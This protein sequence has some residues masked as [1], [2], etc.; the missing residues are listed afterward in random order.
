MAVGALS[1]NQAIKAVA[2]AKSYLVKDQI[3]ISFQ[4][5][6]K[7]DE[8]IAY[9]LVLT[10]TKAPLRTGMATTVASE[11]KVK[12]DSE[13]YKTAGAIA[14]KIREGSRV[15]VVCITFGAETVYVAIDSISIA[16]QYLKRD[17][18]DLTVS[19]EFVHVETAEGERSGLR[20]ELKSFQI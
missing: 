16:R 5:E 10:L 9:N 14:A 2:I 13:S 18:L 12:R 19:P 15:A 4:S 8:E 20:F 7:Q 1:A 17:G 11:I 3:T 6:F